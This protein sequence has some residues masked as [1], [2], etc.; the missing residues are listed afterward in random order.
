[1]P[2]RVTQTLLA[3]T[4]RTAGG[5]GD[6][7]PRLGDWDRCTL[8][9]E[10]TAAAQD[11]GDSLNV[12]VQSSFDGA[13]WYD[14]ASFPTVLG[15]GGPKRYQIRL[16]AVGGTP[17]PDYIEMTDGQMTSGSTPRPVFAPYRMRAKWAIAD[18][19]DA[20]QSFTFG[21]NAHFEYGG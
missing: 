20:D 16:S 18:S 5:T 4:A 6:A 17:V 15:N 10:V 11:A 9:L 2:Q 14:V 8:V 21:L 1:M 12:Y 7:L 13:V 19:G 3:A